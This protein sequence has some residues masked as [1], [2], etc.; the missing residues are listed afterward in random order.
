MGV[1]IVH[2]Q[3]TMGRVVAARRKINGHTAAAITTVVQ[4]RL[5]QG[6]GFGA[7]DSGLC[8]PWKKAHAGSELARGY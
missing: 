8:Q 1:D 4:E 2:C 7:Y 6:L 3:D 5:D